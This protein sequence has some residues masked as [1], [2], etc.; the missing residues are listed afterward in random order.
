MNEPAKISFDNTE[1]A[2]AARSDKELKKAHFLF[3]A[4]G[5]PWLVKAGLK[6]TPWAIRWHLPFTKPIIR[7][8]IFRQFVGGETL[9]ETA[10][11]ADKLEQYKVQ[12]ILDYGVEGKEGEDNFEHAR[13][14]FKKVIEYAAT[15]TNIP[16]MS[17]KV[18]GF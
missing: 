16:F 15:Q 8:T 2:F 12:V 1:Y 3:S 11:V 18:T 10:K 7:N 13:D 4:M 9:E 17:V 14:E 5:K 6:L